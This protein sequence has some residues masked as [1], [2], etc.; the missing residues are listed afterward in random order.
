MHLYNAFV[1]FLSASKSKYGQQ[2]HGIIN[3]NSHSASIALDWA[4]RDTGRVQNWSEI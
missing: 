2:K 1:Q 4:W 3:S